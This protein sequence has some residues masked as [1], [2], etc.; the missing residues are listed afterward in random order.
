MQQK[1]LFKKKK[2]IS[3]DIKVRFFELNDD[4]EVIWEDFGK[5]SEADVHHQY[6]IALKTPPYK[7]INITEYV[8]YFIFL[9]IIFFIENK[10]HL[11]P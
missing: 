1:N 10:I 7:D 8:N 3:E 6:A 11:F 2:K 9:F 5:F 4:K